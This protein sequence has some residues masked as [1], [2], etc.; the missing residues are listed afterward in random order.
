[1]AASVPPEI[2][3]KLSRLQPLSEEEERQYGAGIDWQLVWEQTRS[4]V[5]EVF[6]RSRVDFSRD[7]GW[8]GSAEGIP[9]RPDQPRPTSVA[10][11]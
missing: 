6:W 7:E 2:Y 11:G 5:Y 9:S 8:L 10:E 3:R 1:M 4:K